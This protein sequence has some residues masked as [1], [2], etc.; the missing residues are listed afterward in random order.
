M[1]QFQLAF[2]DLLIIK[3]ADYLF[4]MPVMRSNY[5]SQGIRYE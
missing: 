5:K 3:N 4:R 1:K 2:S